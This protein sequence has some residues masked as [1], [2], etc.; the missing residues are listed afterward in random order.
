M[1]PAVPLKLVLVRFDNV[2]VVPAATVIVLAAT[3]V[4]IR[5]LKVTL[6][7]ITTFP[8]QVVE[9]APASAPAV[10]VRLL[11][12]DNA[13][14]R[15]IV[16]VAAFT[17]RAPGKVFAF[18][19]TVLVLVIVTEVVAAVPVIVWFDPKVQDPEQDQVDV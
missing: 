13:S 11:A 5:R 1:L 17:I 15:V 7:E 4:K 16:F 19:V 18:E 9:K 12:I 8:A 14:A 6:A 10:K 2:S 3:L